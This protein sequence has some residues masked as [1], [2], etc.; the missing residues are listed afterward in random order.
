MDR[1]KTTAQTLKGL[2]CD[3]WNM[4]QRLFIRAGRANVDD[5]HRNVLPRCCDNETV[6][7]VDLERRACSNDPVR[8]GH[9]IK[10]LVHDRR[11][12]VL[13]KKYNIGFHDAAAARAARQME[14]LVVI[15]RHDL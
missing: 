1:C 4:E 15:P 11:G 2:A 8:L 7:R 3:G 5:H 13:A 12:H 14:I 9:D 10:G 6:H